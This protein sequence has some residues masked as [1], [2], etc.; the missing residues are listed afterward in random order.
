MTRTILMAALVGALVLAG[1]CSEE[2]QQRY[3]RAG[4]NLEAAKRAHAEA[5]QAVTEKK[6]ELARLQEKLDAAERRLIQ[7]RERMAE[8][9]QKLERS[10]NDEVLFRSIQRALLD[11]SRFADAAVAVGVEDRVVTLTGTV[12]DEATREAAMEVARGHAGVEGVVDNLEVAGAGEA[13][14]KAPEPDASS[15][16]SPSPSPS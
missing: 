8:A 6:A 1:G 15:T 10:V 14:E 9:K 2:P 11:E 4:A 13:S 7:A 5:Q 16:L 3:E 12:P